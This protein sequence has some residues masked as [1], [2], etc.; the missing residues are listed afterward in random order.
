MPDARFC[1]YPAMKKIVLILFVLGLL[2][3]MFMPRWARVGGISWWHITVPGSSST[4]CIVEVVSWQGETIYC[5][6]FSPPVDVSV[7]H[8]GYLMLTTWRDGDPPRY[9][10]VQERKF[11]SRQELSR[12]KPARVPRPSSNIYDDWALTDLYNI[13]GG[14]QFQVKEDWIRY[15]EQNLPRS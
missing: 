2:L 10:D 5:R 15:V 7:E 3:M 11:I 8:E 13:A 4:Q 12:R 9:Y 1:F 6:F 14:T